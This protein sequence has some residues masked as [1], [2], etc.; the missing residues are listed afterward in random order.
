MPPTRFWNA[1]VRIEGARFGRPAE[2]ARRPC[3]GAWG[4]HVPARRR[5]LPLTG[6]G[7]G[8]SGGPCRARPWRLGRGPC[9]AGPRRL[10]RPLPG[11]VPVPRA[12]PARPGTAATRRRCPGGL[13][14]RGSRFSGGG[15]LPGRCPGS[16][17][18]PGPVYSARRPRRRAGTSR[19][20]RRRLGGPPVSSPGL[21]GRPVDAPPGGDPV[22]SALPRGDR[23]A[24]APRP[25]GDSPADAPSARGD[26]VSSPLPRS[27]PPGV[28]APAPGT[29]WCLCSC[30]GRPP[31]ISPPPGEARGRCLPGPG[32]WPEFPGPRGTELSSTSLSGI[33]RSRGTRR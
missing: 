23:S 4:V 33:P 9:R 18:A 5:R 21:G 32:R 25:L 30:P 20:L 3:T 15:P 27:E 19:R 17:E 31:G 1:R 12:G 29:A 24:D 26:P 10:V 6:P 11:P 14:S 2:P 13:A 8:A 16:R 28:C 7:P 22:S